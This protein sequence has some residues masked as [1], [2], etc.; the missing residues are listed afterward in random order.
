MKK[1]LFL[2]MGAI[3]TVFA[4]QMIENKYNF[5]VV[6]DEERKKDTLKT[7]LL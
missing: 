2:G 5:K 4:S 6:C 3:G 7:D 1:I